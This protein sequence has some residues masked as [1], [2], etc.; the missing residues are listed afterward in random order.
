[1][2]HLLTPCYVFDAVTDITPE[3]LTAHGIRGCLIDLDGTL[4]SRHQPTGNPRL[5][6]WLDTLR[7]ADIRPLLLSNNNGNRVRIFAESIGVEWQGRALKPLSRGFRKGAAR[8]GLPFH[9]I[10][11]IG[12]QIYTDI[13][14]GNRL[15]AL[16]CYIETIDR[17]EFWIGARYRFLE[18]AFIRRA[19]R[20]NQN[21][22]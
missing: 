8:L 3:F 1:M 13:L 10:A 2:K 4:V 15:G 6:E 7:T 22:N 5:M 16:T 19:R 11:V 9:Q 17:G 18:S 12:D 14:G 20:R 21:G